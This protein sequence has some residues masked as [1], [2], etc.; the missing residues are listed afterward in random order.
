MSIR[1]NADREDL[2][3][4]LDPEV[5]AQRNLVAN[6]ATDPKDLMLEEVDPLVAKPAKENPHPAEGKKH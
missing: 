2:A 5:E 1:S 6:P 3:G 4:K